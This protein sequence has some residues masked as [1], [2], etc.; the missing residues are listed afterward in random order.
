MRVISSIYLSHLHNGE[1]VAF[2]LETLEQLDHAGLSGLG[3][4]EQV[5]EYRTVQAELKLSLDV[6]SASDLS[7]ELIRMDKQR[8]RSYS[9]FKSY[10]KVYLNDDD[11]QKIEAAERIM[12]V[13][14]KSASEVGNPLLLGMTKETTALSS[15]IRNL[16][17]LA[18]DIELIG[19]SNRLN[20]LKETNQ[21]FTGLQFDRTIEQS[22]KHSGDVKAARIVADAVYKKITERINAQIL[23]N[24]DEAFIPYIKAEEAVIEKYNNLLAKR[25]GLA[26]KT[27][28]DSNKE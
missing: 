8:D 7:T 1:N 3:V 15:L 11:E 12:S 18:G 5:D 9:A 19:A 16:E 22:L 27:V 21:Q 6:F 13:I 26:K 28:T 23:L 2:H 24:S 10:I 14:R 25:K 4:Q 20:R 17:P